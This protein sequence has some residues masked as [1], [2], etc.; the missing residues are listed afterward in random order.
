MSRIT[1][2]STYLPDNIL[3]NH[4]LSLRFPSWTPEKIFQ[5]TGIRERRIASE[6]QTAS[7]LAYLAAENLFSTHSI[8]RT[9]IDCLIF[10]TQTPDQAL[11]TSACLL[12]GR[13]KLATSCAAFDINQG[14]SGYI[15]GLAVA[16]GLISSGAA[17]NVLL[18]TADTY[19]KL[20]DPT[21]H[22]V[23]TLFGDAASASLLTSDTPPTASSI[24]PT[25][26]GT[27]SSGAS[28][29]YCTYTG[30]RVPISMQQPLSMDGPSILS[31]TLSTLP[32]SLND[33]LA[34]SNLAIDSFDHIIFHQA[35]KFILDKLYAKVGATHKGIIDLEYCGNTVSSSIP[36]ALAPF[37]NQSLPQGTRRI[38]LSGFGVGLSW[39]FTTIVI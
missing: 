27:D 14:C 39:G 20:I 7:D 16:D 3:S 26:F 34:L 11:P 32:S 30:W 38:L 35:N 6:D 2:I 36:L 37:F 24:G 8:D 1:A 12:H 29:L 10:V 4:D 22:S 33:Y 17:S 28:S 31:F 15:Y 25:L 13:L 19:S 23:L 9:C 21:D 18:L 5:K